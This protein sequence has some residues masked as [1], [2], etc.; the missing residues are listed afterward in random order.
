MVARFVVEL[1][2]VFAVPIKVGRVQQVRAEVDGVPQREQLALLLQHLVARQPD[3]ASA[4]QVLR[5]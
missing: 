5:V 4:F 3:L 1:F 2:E